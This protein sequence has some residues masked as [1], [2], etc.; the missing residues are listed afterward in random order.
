M[1]TKE[2][3]IARRGRRKA[4]TQPTSVLLVPDCREPV[5][6]A[7]K[8]YY[9]TGQSN[10]SE[11]FSFSHRFST[12]A[13]DNIWINVNKDAIKTS[14]EKKTERRNNIR[15][16]PNEKSERGMIRIDFVEYLYRS[17]ET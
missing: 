7:L 5:G 10:Q 1:R 17:V 6:R 2:P 13:I 3:Y 4:A 12:N 9:I 8:A 14:T 15:I 16:P 11:N